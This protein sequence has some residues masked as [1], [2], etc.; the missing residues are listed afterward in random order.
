MKADIREESP[1]LQDTKDK[2]EDQVK[3]EYFD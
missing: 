3:S 1:E 2:K